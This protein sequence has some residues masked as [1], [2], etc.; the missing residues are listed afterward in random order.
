MKL[1]AD[2]H[3]HSKYSRFGHGKN[4]IEEMAIAANEMGL[5]E[6]GITDHGYKHFFRTTKNIVPFS[7]PCVK[8]TAGCRCRAKHN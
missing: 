6:I 7:A 4:S 5:V 1:L 3:T 8:D 2:L